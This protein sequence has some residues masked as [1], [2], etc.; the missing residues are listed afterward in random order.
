MASAAAAIAASAIAAT[1]SVAVPMVANATNNSNLTFGQQ[2]QML[3]E[4]QQLNVGAYKQQTWLNRETQQK[5]Y[6]QN[7]ELVKLEHSNLIKTKNL[8]FE[9]STQ[10]E[11]LRH[12]NASSAA[13]VQYQYNNF[14]AANNLSNSK[15]FAQFSNDLSVAR[16]QNIISTL[17][18][19]GVPAS[20]YYLG[21]QRPSTLQYLGSNSTHFNFGS[22]PLPYTGTEAQRSLSTG[23]VRL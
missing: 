6:E 23:T 10:L 1:A 20:F 5:L 21:I 2:V 8:E 9:H 7:S 15:S 14:T 17:K 4:Q 22:N 12:Q 16:E 3:S 19:E 13:D 11:N 18:S